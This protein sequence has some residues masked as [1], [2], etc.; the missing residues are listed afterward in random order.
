MKR[1]VIGISGASGII[2][3][4]KTIIAL[5]SAGLAV[6]LIITKHA[7]YAASLE[8]GKEMAT[9]SKFLASFPN[10][11][12]KEITLHKAGDIGATVASGSYQTQAMVIIPCS[13]ASVAAI[14]CGL[15]DNL[16][17]RAADVTL[18]EKRPLILVPREAP[19]SQLHLENLLRLSKL[20]ATIVPPLPA[21]YTQPKTIDD[22]ENFIVGKVLDTLKVEHSLYPRWQG[23]KRG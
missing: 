2:L 3:A 5:V 23:A 19:L 14:A 10:Q 4:Q 12:Q 18:K 1:I 11:I 8:I 17:R 21:W 16:L 9:E 7:L 22:V 20:G 15:A 13:M 6:D